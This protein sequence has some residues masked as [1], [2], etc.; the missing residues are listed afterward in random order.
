VA[1]RADVAFGY[2]HAGEALY[3]QW[4]VR[5]SEQ[6]EWTE[7]AAGSPEIDAT[8]V[9]SDAIISIECR[10]G[11]DPADFDGTIGDNEELLEAASVRVLF[12][13]D[14]SRSARVSSSVLAEPI[15]GAES[16]LVAKW[17]SNRA[18]LA[19]NLVFGPVMVR[20]AFGSD[21]GLAAY[22]GEELADSPDKLTLVLASTDKTVGSDIEIG[23]ASFEDKYPDDLDKPWKLILNGAETPRLILDKDIEGLSEV[24]NS[25]QKQGLTAERRD[26]LTMAIA[27]PVWS[28]LVISALA[29]SVKGLQLSAGEP[30]P[31]EAAADDWR[32]RA[33]A[34]AAA[35]LNPKEPEEVRVQALLKLYLNDPH[36]AVAK[37][38]NISHRRHGNRKTFKKVA[39]A[40][41]KG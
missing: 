16:E 29:D 26:S 21:P 1:N 20:R 25:Q 12:Q 39:A 13:S 8:W 33:I 37:V 23:W 32:Y 10:V 38:A 3:A 2:P 11:L 27:E 4:R 6:G 15:D 22:P 5:L 9:Q 17:S 24:L 31:I 14:V 28:A 19:G 41:A 40:V 7:W 30:V 36:E 34:D 18:D 35:L